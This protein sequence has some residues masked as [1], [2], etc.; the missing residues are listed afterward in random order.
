M[1]LPDPVID[2]HEDFFIVRDD[3]IEGGT[4]RRVIHVLFDEAHT[5]Y[6]Y[7]SPVFGYAQVALAYACRDAGKR[8]TI[9][10]AQR[11]HRHA[12]TA[13]AEAAGAKIVEVP[14]GYLVVVQARAREYAAMF[15]AK[16]LPFGLSTPEVVAALAD[17][18]RGLPMVPSEV[19]CVVGSG[20]LSRALQLAWPSA[21]FFGV[22]VGAEPDAGRAK[23]FTAPEKYQHAAKWL[24]P[25]PSC[26]NYDAKAWRFL[27]GFAS[28]GALFWNVAA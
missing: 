4:K 28:P 11:K 23:I 13:E 2:A 9:F 3:L 18:A 8:A 19:W 24:P 27:K 6:V 22:K 16:L 7:A 10:C 26:E 20:T 1:Q 17:V 12:L 25:F 21:T 14:A 15:G 5:E